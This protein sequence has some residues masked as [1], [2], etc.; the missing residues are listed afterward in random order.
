MDLS[1]A[2]G[3]VYLTIPTIILLFEEFVPNY[4]ISIW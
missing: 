3:D 4:T 2:A 1:M